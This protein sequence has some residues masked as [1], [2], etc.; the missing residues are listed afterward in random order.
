MDVALTIDIIVCTVL[1]AVGAV[2]M[3][4]ALVIAQVSA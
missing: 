3:I 2:A 4:V 1:T